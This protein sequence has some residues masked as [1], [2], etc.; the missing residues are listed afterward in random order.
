MAWQFLRL[1]L[2]LN[3]AA[4]SIA[5]LTFLLFLA[6]GSNEWMLMAAAAVCSGS[7]VWVYSDF[8]A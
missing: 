7:F 1:I 2:A 6:A 5:G 4:A 3:F 8:T